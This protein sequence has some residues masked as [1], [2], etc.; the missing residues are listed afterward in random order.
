MNVKYILA[1]AGYTELDVNEMACV[2]MEDRLA[3]PMEIGLFR[4]AQELITNV[5]RHANATDASVQI[6]RDD[7]EVRLTV[8]D[9]GSG[10]D[11]H[12]SHTGMGHRNIAARAAAIGGTLHYDSTLGRGTTVTVVVDADAHALS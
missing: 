12:A 6:M 9:N 11:M 3:E 8:E 4:V 10:F 1:I 7:D 2:G 5:L